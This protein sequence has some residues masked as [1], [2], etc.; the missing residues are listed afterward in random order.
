MSVLGLK[1]GYTLKYG[2]SPRDCTRAPPSGNSLGSGHI[3][4]YFPPLVLIRIQ[5]LLVPHIYVVY[6]CIAMFIYLVKLLYRNFSVGVHKYS[7]WNFGVQ[8][9]RC[10]CIIGHKDKFGIVSLI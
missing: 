6:Q 7:Q 8:M 9:T 5:N 2:L 4:P 3:L 10:S 1:A